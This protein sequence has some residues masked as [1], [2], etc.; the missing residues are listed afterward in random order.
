[1]YHDV[2]LAVHVTIRPPN[3]LLAS[4]TMA[5]SKGIYIAAA[6]RTPFGT[7]GGALTKFSATDLGVHAAKAALADTN[8]DPAAVEATIF[9]N[10]AQSSPDAPYMA[11]HIG[12]KAG[13]KNSSTAI[14]L[15]RLCGSGFQAVITAA[16]EMQLGQ[17]NVALAGGAES[18]SQC[19]LST[20]GQDARFGVKLG[21]GVQLTD[22]LWAALTDT[23]TGLPMGI[24][25]EKLAEQYDI[26]RADCEE[27]AARSQQAWGA[28]NEAGVF[29][30]EIAP[31]DIKTRKGVVAMDTDEYPRPGTTAESLSKLPAVFK[32]GGVVTAGTASGINDGAAALLVATEDAVKQHGLTPLA[33]VVSYGIAG[34]DPSIMGIG[35]C[36]A[37]R[38]ALEA[39]GLTLA[40]M[41]Q[42]EIN[43]A[44][45]AQYIACEKEL[46]LDR[47]ISNINGG[48]I[49]LG[50]PLGA[51]G[52]RILAHLS[53]Q[54]A[55][56]PDNKYAV[57]SA[58]I[59]GGQGIAVVLERA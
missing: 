31:V 38:Q 59:G 48:A 8:L 13:A 41:D 37:I 5:L 52:A 36:P 3:I 17:Y 1:M 18:M 2:D 10:V 51:S 19:P 6:K 23:Y 34:V 16:Q 45:A 26:S 40:D 28:A 56:K 11:R 24:T 30:A 39:A 50:H 32:K 4:V 35:P 54:L 57:G 14:T 29:K 7:F 15:N 53:H 33:R 25:A 22:T 20:Y 42:V 12:L 58:C 44:F 21:A 43:E 47:N 9:G 46:G 55:A 27:L 49:A